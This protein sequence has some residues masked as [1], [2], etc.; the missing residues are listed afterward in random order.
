MFSGDLAKNVSNCRGLAIT[1][2]V[3]R[4]N[5]PAVVSHFSVVVNHFVF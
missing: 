1:E 5:W 2:E 4:K 3:L